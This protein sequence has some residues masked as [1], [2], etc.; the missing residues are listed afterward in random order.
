MYLTK[1]MDYFDLQEGYDSLSDA[2]SEYKGKYLVL[3]YS[4]DWLFPTYQVKDLV[5]AL[6]T[7]RVDVSFCEIQSDYGHDSFLLKNDVQERLL[8]GFL[9]NIEE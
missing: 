9:A 3:T 1:A 6:R 7:N 8:S 5:T 2:L 4:S